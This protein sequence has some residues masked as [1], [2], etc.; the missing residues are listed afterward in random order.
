MARSIKPETRPDRTTPA[1][2]SDVSLGMMPNLLGYALRNTHNIVSSM[3]ISGLADL[4]LYPTQVSVLVVIDKNDGINQAL[5][6]KAVGIKKGNLATL[7]DG[8]EQRG[9]VRRELP[10]AGRRGNGMHLTDEGRRLVERARMASLDKEDEIY[11]K[12]GADDYN[13]LI[14]LLHKVVKKLQPET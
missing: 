13:A 6:G 2:E 7:I 8:L 9:L 10:A 12:I 1:K 14:G 4:K 11:D 3:V 5:I